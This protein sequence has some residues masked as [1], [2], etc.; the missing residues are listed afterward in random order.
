MAGGLGLPLRQGHSQV[1]RWVWI[2]VW[3]PSGP[4]PVGIRIL[5]GPRTPLA[6]PGGGFS[7]AGTRACGCHSL[8]SRES[9]EKGSLQRGQTEQGAEFGSAAVGWPDSRGLG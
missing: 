4:R 7:S 3:S 1:G 2:S 8:G 5:L 6:C 9:Q